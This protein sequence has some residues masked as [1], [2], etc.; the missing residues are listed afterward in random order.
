MPANFHGQLF[1]LLA[2]ADFVSYDIIREKLLAT[3][4][5]PDGVPLHMLTAFL[6]GTIAVTICAPVDVIKSRIQ[7]NRKAGVVSNSYPLIGSPADH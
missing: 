4:Y 2:I 3:G 7:S 6:G 5:L 1:R